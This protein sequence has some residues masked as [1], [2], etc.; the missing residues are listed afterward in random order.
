MASRRNPRR[1]SV[2][3][4]VLF[5]LLLLVFAWGLWL[6]FQSYQQQRSSISEVSQEVTLF[7]EKIQVY[8]EG[9][10]AEQETAPDPT[11]ATAPEYL[12]DLWENMVRYN[13]EIY[14]EG[15]EGLVDAWSYIVD[16]FDIKNWGIDD[17]VIGVVT[18]PKIDAEMPLYVGASMEH[19]G[20]GCAVLTQTSMPIGGENTNCVIA[21]H[22]GWNGIPFVRDIEEVTIGDS[23]FV[24][25]LWETL[26]YRVTEI[27][28]IYPYES[29]HILIQPGKDMITILTCHPHGVNSHRYLV[30]A[31]RYTEP[32]QEETQ[33]EGHWET[34]IVT[35]AVITSSQGI[36]FESSQHEIFLTSWLPVI[37]LFIA[38]FLFCILVTIFFFHLIRYTIL[39]LR[40]L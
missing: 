14:D 13:Q 7:K 29:Q 8:K 1:L 39:W 32:E 27:K 34:K 15:Q 40:N 37:L 35:S 2:V 21:A 25:N 38:L 33:A 16:P 30:Y 28:V 22:R 17:E 36:E 19:L 3:Q 11:E 26:E 23:I 24:E 18:I 9:S 5:F 20:K 12:A 10:S 4:L 6:S 31:E